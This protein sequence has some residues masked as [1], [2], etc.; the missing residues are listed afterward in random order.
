MAARAPRILPLASAVLVLAGVWSG[1]F[2]AVPTVPPVVQ[3]EPAAVRDLRIQPPPS[4]QV[5][6]SEEQANK[7]IVLQWHYEFFD[8]GHFKEAADK[9]LAAD[10]R[11]NDPD[12]QSGRSAYVSEFEHNGYIPRP[13]AER[14][15][16]IAVLAD[17]DLVMMVIPATRDASGHY[18]EAGFIHCNLF[19]VQGGL[20]Q[21]M[22]VS[23]DAAKPA[24]S[25]TAK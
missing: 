21:S 3:D 12:E 7:R 20:I 6:T 14:P 4:Q 2:S 9:Y 8:L 5:S 25:A 13:A 10:F 17:G 16:L 1:A 11:Q 24:T 15:P 19:R 23:A 18:N 22:W